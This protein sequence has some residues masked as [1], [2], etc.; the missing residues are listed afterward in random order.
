VDTHTTMASKSTLKWGDEVD[1]DLESDPESHPKSNLNLVTEQAEITEQDGIQTR[2]EIITLK[3]GQK[4]MQIRKVKV[5]TVVQTVSQN[6]LK[7]RQ[8]KKF[9]KCAGR[10]PGPEPSI[11]YSAPE[12]VVLVLRLPDVFTSR[13]TSLSNCIPPTITKSSRASLTSLGSSSK[14]STVNSTGP[15]ATKYIPINKRNPHLATHL[16]PAPLPPSS[17]PFFVRGTREPALPQHQ[18]YI[19]N[20]SPDCTE[21]ELKMYCSSF[22]YV[23]RVKIPKLDGESRRFA[24]VSFTNAESVDRAITALHNKAYKNTILTVNIAKGPPPRLTH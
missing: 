1:S 15:A 3:N 10:P 20:L 9:G 16:P 17:D 24:F 22:G 13:L 4:A 5:T 6:V 23:P 7:R 14:A 11:T 8:W 19:G 12:D 2:K 18:I 21:E